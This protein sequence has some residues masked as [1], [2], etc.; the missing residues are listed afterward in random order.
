[1]LTI[2]LRYDAGTLVFD[3]LA[4]DAEPSLVSP[5]AVWDDRVRR[6]RAQGYRYREVVTHL[7]RAQ[8]AGTIAF[9]DSARKYN[10]LSLEHRTARTPFEHQSESIARWRAQGQRGIVVLPTGAGKTFV[11]E[12]AIIAVQRSTMVIAPTIDLMSQWYDVLST[13]FH[14]EI[15]LLGGGYHEIRDITV[16]TYDSAYIHADAYGNRFG[17]V[18]FDECHHL[19]SPTYLMGSEAMIAPYRLGLTATLERSDGREHLL[20]DR[21]G[22]VAYARGIKD[23]AG[24]HLA[25]YD[26]YTMSAKLS[27]EEAVVYEESR[28]LYRQFLRDKG[29]DMSKPEG[30][31]RFIMLSSR[32]REGRRAFMAYRAQRQ[33][34]ITPASKIDVLEGLLRQHAKD[35]VIV[36]TND[37]ETVY[38]ISKTFLLPAIT[39]Q[40][41]VKE[42]KE[43]LERFNRGAYPAVVTSRVLN[44]GVNVPDANVA[45]I[46]SGTGSVR[47]H[48]Q[49]LGRVLRRKEGKRAVLYEVITERTVEERVSGRRRE[50]DAYR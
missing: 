21:V 3:G 48:V 12:L 28:E 25:D 16:S 18:V 42:R 11:A 14:S 41:D 50:H 20:D 34:A 15:G 19:P 30:W 8:R 36:F 5:H 46:L 10:E 40:T 7:V 6:Y 23:L 1:M 27:E 13:A 26:V 31:S 24:S 45:I 4:R 37:N 17:L 39:H 44:E 29:I 35:R 2:T 32:S 47:E 43:I 33:V 49:R 38:R 22:P 9:E